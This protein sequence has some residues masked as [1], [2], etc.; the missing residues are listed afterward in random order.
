[1]RVKKRT[2]LAMLL[3]YRVLVEKA[4][5]SYGL[6]ADREQLRSLKHVAFAANLTNTKLE[7]GLALG[8]V[9]GSLVAL[10]L[11]KLSAINA[12]NAVGC[13]IDVQDSRV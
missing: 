7:V 13:V 9:Q 2:A 4:G 1:M 5:P 10:G 3:Q 8:F 6:E 11:R 12:D